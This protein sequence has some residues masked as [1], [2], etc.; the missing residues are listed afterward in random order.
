MFKDRVKHVTWTVQP[1]T[2]PGLWV[3]VRLDVTGQETV[4]SAPVTYREAMAIKMRRE[5]LEVFP[6]S[7]IKG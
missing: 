3:V 2:D 4:V 5:I 6:D 1:A 7:K